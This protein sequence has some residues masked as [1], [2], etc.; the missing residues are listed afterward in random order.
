MCSLASVEVAEFSIIDLKHGIQHGGISISFG[1]VAY[2]V[3]GIGTALKLVLWLY[4]KRV[5]VG[6]FLYAADCAVYLGLS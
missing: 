6:L 4:C 2:L 1:L 3:L 5:E